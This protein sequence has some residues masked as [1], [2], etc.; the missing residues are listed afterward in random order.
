MAVAI[1]TAAEAATLTI[2]TSSLPNGVVARSYS[3]SVLATGG[4]RPFTYSISAGSIPSGLTFSSSTGRFAGRPV[5]SGVSNF[6]VTVT[7]H[8]LA[9]ASKAFAI[10]VSPAPLRIV[11][12]SLPAGKTGTAYFATLAATGGDPPLTWGIT[13]GALPAGLILNT[14]NGQISGTPTAVGSFPITV[15]VHDS[16][17]P[18]TLITKSLTLRVTASPLSVSTASLP[19]GA[20][21][22]DYSA[23]LAAAGGVPPYT[24]TVSTGALPGGLTL[25]SNGAITGNPTSAGTSTFTA[26]VTDSAAKTATKQLSITINGSLS[27]PATALPQGAVGLAYT[28]TLPV[29]GGSAP[30]ALSVTGGSLPP[31]LSLAGATGTISGTPTGSGGTYVFTAHATDASNPT[32]Q[33]DQNYTITIVPALA[34][35]TTTLG[36]AITATPYSTTLNATGGTTPYLWTM[37]S[38]T[39]PAGLSLI[40]NGVINGAPTTAG[41]FNFT[42]RATDNGTPAQVKTKALSIKVIQQLVITTSSL[43]GGI[44]GSGYSKSLASSGG[45]GPFA[46]SLDSGTLPAGITLSG[47]GVLSGTPSVQGVSS[48]DVKVADSAGQ[49]AIRTFSITVNPVLNI[50]TET[51]DGGLQG[52]PYAKSLEA[53]GGSAPLTWSLT[54][55]A[56]PAGLALSPAGLISG[57][58]TAL[59]TS[60]FTVKVADSSSPVQEIPRSFSIKIVKPLVISTA[61]LA[62]GVIGSPY[63]SSLAATGG[64]VPYVWSVIGGTLPTGLTLD[65]STG[66]ITGSPTTAGTSNITIQVA[67]ASAPQQLTT[68]AFSIAIAALLTITNST[69]PEAQ[70]GH[71]YSVTLVPA[72]GTAPFVWSVTSGTLPAGISLNTSTGVLSGTPT[73]AGTVSLTFKVVDVSN[74]QQQAS[75][76][77]SLV[78]TVPPFQITTASLPDGTKGVAYSATVGATDGVAPYTWS[79]TGGT[80]PTGLSLNAS[81]GAITGTPTTAGVSTATIQ[82]QDSSPS[83][84][85]TTKSLSITIVNPV[86]IST[87]SLPGGTTSNSYSATLNA[88]GGHPTYSWAITSGTLPAGLAFNGTTGTISGIP[89]GV[90]L[91]TITVQVTDS[92]TP[93]QTSS[94]SFTIDV[95]TV[96]TITTGSI[97]DA[98]VGSGYA[99]TLVASG[100]T[101]PYTWS[102]ISGALPA[103]ITL[104]PTTGEISGT[105]TAAGN[106][107][108]TIKVKDLSSPFQTD[109]KTLTLHVAGLLAISSTTLANGVLS[110][111]YSA[112]LNS[113]GGTA[114]VTWAVTGGA[115]PTGLTLNPNTGAITG[116]PTA[117]GTFNF[118]VTA[119]DTAAPAQHVAKA[120][121]IVVNPT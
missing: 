96:I 59:G 7:D 116:T 92:S 16:F 65:G 103:G 2:S 114:P 95:T 80:L 26:K 46:W 107:T 50:V 120:L 66:Q 85:T 109:T 12:T 11:T 105:P 34:I 104:D 118:T 88:A 4:T 61:S 8:V 84:L 29:A 89:T 38:G 40:G 69:L 9:T 110:S 108:F 106:S 25:A 44:I 87:N 70:V 48:F 101:T 30:Y 5:Q 78:R 19:V 35:T 39:L 20:A 57:T 55:G 15:T 32:Q 94:K 73:T 68:K 115:L 58:P 31:G 28:T 51:L 72:G 24:W 74:P 42:V 75:K 111:P 49:S 53:N 91:S 71:P 10:S 121:S 64:S 33:A 82:A 1:P 67:D 98:V 21:G 43:P 41:T 45:T 77:F 83:P 112:T 56:L 54:S 97:P 93:A 90:G 17:S 113:T 14:S 86:S 27:L 102:V 81:T 79:V 6:Q 117:L 52:V 3:A 60:T 13:N 63:T 100:G 119:T 23:N 62:S 18:G 47:A 76:T 36:D 22:A 37:E 99:T